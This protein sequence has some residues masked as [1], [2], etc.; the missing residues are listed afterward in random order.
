[1]SEKGPESEAVERL[2]PELP[3][4]PAVE[5]Y[6]REGSA[7]GGREID[8]AGADESLHRLG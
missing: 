2:V 5:K 7:A 3:P 8:S 4:R 1:V 6:A